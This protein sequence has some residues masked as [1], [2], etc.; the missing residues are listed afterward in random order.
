MPRTPAGGTGADMRCKTRVLDK[1]PTKPEELPAWNY[2]G[3]STGQA[4]RAGG[5]AGRGRGG[6]GASRCAAAAGP[7]GHP[8]QTLG[9]QPLSPI[10]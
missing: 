5:G 3:S 1:L 6:G 8:V 2:D 4:S 7:P 9:R 10:A